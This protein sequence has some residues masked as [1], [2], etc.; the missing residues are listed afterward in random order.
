MS[1]GYRSL[2]TSNG[3][4]ANSR[5]ANHPLLFR[6]DMRIFGQAENRL[7]LGDTKNRFRRTYTRSFSGLFIENV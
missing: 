6:I 2:E 5:R 4:L 7:T 3:K 1:P